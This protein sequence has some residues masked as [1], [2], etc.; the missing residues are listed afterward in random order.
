MPNMATENKMLEKVRITDVSIRDKKKNGDIYTTKNGNQYKLA[1]LRDNQNRFISGYVF[2]EKT[3]NEI[4]NFKGEMVDLIISENDKGF[5]NFK[6]PLPTDILKEEIQELRT[7]FNIL[8]NY[9]KTKLIPRVEKIELN[10]NK[11][12]SKY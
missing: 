1:T 8:K 4:L 3:E 11:E 6:I 12:A 9:I 5:L 2:N 10:N 7:E